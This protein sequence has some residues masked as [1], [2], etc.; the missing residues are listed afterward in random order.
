MIEN[1]TDE[2]KNEENQLWAIFVFPYSCFTDF[3][4][5]KWRREVVGKS[6]NTGHVH[7]NN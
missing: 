4:F 3:L 5:V 1:E 6:K 2:N 7:C